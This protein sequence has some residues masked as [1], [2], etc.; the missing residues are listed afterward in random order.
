MIFI[1]HN[2][3]IS[4][5][6][7]M[8]K[9]LNGG[10]FVWNFDEFFFWNSRNGITEIELQKK[11]SFRSSHISVSSQKSRPPRSIGYQATNNL[12]STQ[13]QAEEVRLWTVR[14]KDLPNGSLFLREGNPVCS[15]KEKNSKIFR[16][17]GL[18]VSN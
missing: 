10:F 8:W 1:K 2:N 7:C 14:M 6:S 18:E 13:L 11:S 15:F 5:R 12:I 17:F 4:R 16:Y 9:P 3:L